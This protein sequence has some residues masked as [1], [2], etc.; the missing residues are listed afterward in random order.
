MS[1]FD[2]IVAA[3]TPPESE[4]DR[5]KARQKARAVAQPGDWL[6]QILGHHEQIE[7][8]FARAEA[9]NDA[10]SRKQAVKE[11]GALLTGHSSAEEA[12]IYPQLSEDHKGQLGLSYQEQQ[13][14]KVEMALL[15]ALDP[16]SQDWIDKLGHIKGA[17]AHHVYEEEGD[18]FLNLKKEL[19]LAAQARMTER[20]REETQRYD[21]GLAG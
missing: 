5:A 13:A 10:Q 17:V 19:P 8:A 9:A 16:M 2:K 12:V 20:Y 14:A 15:E 18:R 21:G 11:L 3:V 6:D 4:E 1:V 7:G